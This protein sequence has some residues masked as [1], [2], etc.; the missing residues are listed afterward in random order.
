MSDPFFELCRR[1]EIR[2]NLVWD[3]VYRSKNIHDDLNPKWEPDSVPLSQLCGGDVHLPI[4]IEVFDHERSGKHV[5][6]GF[7]ETTVATLVERAKPENKSKCMKLMQSNKEEGDLFVEKAEVAVPEGSDRS[8]FPFASVMDEEKPDFV[9][10][11]NGGCGM[12][13]VVGIDYTASNGDPRTAESLHYLE[14][15]ENGVPNDYQTAL[16][17]IV[18]ILAKYDSDMRFPVFGFGAK[19]DGVVH[20]SFQVGLSAE[21]NGVDGVLSAYKSAFST[22]MVMSSQPTDYTEIMRISAKHAHKELDKALQGGGQA[23]TVLLIVTDGVGVDTT[24]AIEF[25]KE[26]ADAPLSIIIVGVGKGTFTEMEHLDHARNDVGRDMVKF[27]HFEKYRDNVY[28]LTDATLSELP[29]QLVDYFQSRGMDP[30]PPVE[31]KAEDLE[32]ELEDGD[33]DLGDSYDADE[34]RVTH[35]G[36]NEFEAFVP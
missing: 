22:G 6:I 1:V 23:Y 32:A 35:G 21:V 28:A 7:S 5:L 24:A 36:V 3:V 13:V 20:N 30:L 16:K 29:E 27:V 12:R 18:G 31:V 25:L 8:S 10:Y 33:I 15:N 17:S 11:I 9:E 4:R 26:I 19:F 34:V 2:G 14:N